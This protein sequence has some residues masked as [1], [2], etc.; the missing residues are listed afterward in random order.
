MAWGQRGTHPNSTHPGE[1]KRRGW[2]ANTLT[3]KRDVRRVFARP[4]ARIETPIETEIRQKCP[5]RESNTEETLLFTQRNKKKKKKKKNEKKKNL[6][7][8]LQE[9]KVRRCLFLLI[10]C[11]LT[12]LRLSPPLLPSH[13]GP[14]SSSACQGANWVSHCTSEQMQLT[15]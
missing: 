10:S 13:P 12:S 4:E 11:F 1:G 14:G 5:L 7:K 9:E 6:V 3:G 2:G 8:R 15:Q